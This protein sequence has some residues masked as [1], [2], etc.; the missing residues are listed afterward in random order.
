MSNQSSFAKLFLD[1]CATFG[2]DHTLH[3]NLTLDLIHVYLLAIHHLKVPICVLIPP[4]IVFSPLVMSSSWNRSSLSKL[5]LL[6]NIVLFTSHIYLLKLLLFRSSSA[7][8]QLLRHSIELL[9]LCYLHLLNNS[10]MLF[11]QLYHLV[12]L[13]DPL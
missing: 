9:L 1:V 5:L 11:P 6:L 4:P 7:H 10:S 13:L 3:I 12:H 8:H 2:Y